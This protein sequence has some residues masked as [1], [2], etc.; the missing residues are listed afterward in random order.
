M[1]IYGEKSDALSIRPRGLMLM[2]QG[3]YRWRQG[4]VQATYGRI[5]R[6]S[7]EIYGE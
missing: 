5:Q 7:M 6:K 1:E 4:K 2:G 3:K